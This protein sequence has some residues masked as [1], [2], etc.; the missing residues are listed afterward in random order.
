LN[1][2]LEKQI[3]E[4]EKEIAALSGA[5]YEY[6]FFVACGGF[7]RPLPTKY[8]VIA[9]LRDCG[10]NV[11]DPL[12]HF[13]FRPEITF[14]R[15][16]IPDDNPPNAEWYQVRM[17]GSIHNHGKESLDW[18]HPMLNRRYEEW[19]QQRIVDK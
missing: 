1:K 12:I 6:V 18:C 7:Y 11:I 16:W 8:E 10:L 4:L 3:V 5:T 13:D 2:D 19:K 14:P 17:P 9:W 15:L